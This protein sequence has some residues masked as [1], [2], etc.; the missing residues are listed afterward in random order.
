MILAEETALTKDNSTCLRTEASSTGVVTR[1][2]YYVFRGYRATGQFQM[3]KHE[4]D[5]GTIVHQLS[6]PLF[7]G[8]AVKALHVSLPLFGRAAKPCDDRERTAP[9]LERRVVAARLASTGSA[10]VVGVGHEMAGKESGGSP[11]DALCR[12]RDLP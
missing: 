10:G 11:R 7:T 12:R 3:L 6:L 8:L 2:A 5:R 4:Y 9:S 1:G